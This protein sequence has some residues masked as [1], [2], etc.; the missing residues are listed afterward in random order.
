MAGHAPAPRK[1][2]DPYSNTYNPGWRD[3]PNLSYGGNRQ[4]NFVPNRQQGHQQQY[5]PRPPPP[6]PS[7]SSPSME[8]MMKQLLAN[9]QK[10]DSDLQSMRNQLGQVQSLQN[11]MNQMAITI[12]RLES[13]V[14]G[15]LPSQPEANPKNV[16]AM[17][18]RSGKE[19]QGPEPVIPKDKDEERIEKELEEEGRDNKNTKVPSNPIPTA[20][21][22]PPPF[23]SR[24]E[25]PKKQDK[26]KEV[27]EIFRKVE[28]NIP[29]LDAIKQVPRYAKFLRDLC[30]NRKRLKGDERVIVGENVSAILQRKLPPKC[31]DPGM[32]TI[33][34]RI[35]NI[36]IGKAMLDLGAS[37]NV[38]PKSIY[39]SLNLG[40]LKETGIIIQL[41]DRTN[42]YPD[43]LI[44]DVL[45][46]FEIEDRDELE[47]V[48]TKHFESE[49][50]SGVELS[51]ELKCVI[52]S[53]Q[54]LPTTKTRYDL[55]PIFIPEPHKRL[56]PSVVQA[57][58]LELKPLPKHLKYAYLGEGETLPVIISAGLSK[59]QEEK[60]LRVLR[61]HK[62]AIRWTIAN[63]KGISPAVCMH[64]IR[65]EENSKPVRQAQRRLNP[66]M[67]EVVKKEILKLLDV[68]IIFAISDSPWVSPVQV[69]PKKAGV[70][71][72]SNQEGELVPIRKPTGWR[73]CIDYRKLNAVTKKDHFPLPFIDQM[74]ER[75]ACR[76]YYCF[77]DGF[78]GY[79]QIAIAPEDQEKTTFTCPFGTFAY[80]RMPFGLCNA[81]AT[82]QRCMVSIFSEY[83]EKIIEVFMD[84]FSVYGI[85]VDKAKID[86]IYTLPYP[87]SVREV[88]SFLGHAGFYRRF[89]KD[90][91]K[92][93]APLFQLLQK[94]VSFEF[95]ETCKGAFNKLKEL[96]TTSPIIQ[97]PDWNLPFEIMCDAS[98]Y[99][100]GAVLGQRVG[101]AAHAIY[102]ASRALNGAQL[103][104]STTE[105]ELLAVVFALEKFRSYLL[106]AKVIIF[107]DHAALRYLLTKKE[108]KPRLIRWILL[109][110]EFNLEIRD[111]KG[112]ENLV[113]DH[114]SRV[115]VVEEDLP[116]R[117][118]FPEEH[119]FSINSSL[120]WYA[121]IVN[122]IVTDKFP[123]GWP[124][125]KRD[126]LRS[127]AKFYIWDDPYL[128]KR[129][130]DQIIRRCVCESCDKCQRVGNISRRDQMT[131]T[132]MIFVEIFDVWGIDFMGPFPSSF[133]FL[134]ILLA[135]DYVSKW[136]EAKATRTNDSKVVAEFVKSNIF[137]RFGMPRAIVSDRGTHFCNKTI[138]AIFRRYGVLH[139]VSTSYHPQT[140]GQAE[141]SNRE[142][143]SILEKMVR[144][145]RKDWSVRLED[146]LWAYR[147]AYK[148]PIGMSPYRLVFG[149]PC[150][151]PIEFEHRAFWAVK[152]CNMDIEE[153]GI[154][155]K[156]QLQELEEIRNE[157]YENAVI[158]KEKN[159]IFH[160]QQISRK[161]FFL[162]GFSGYFQIAIAPEDQEKTTFTC[163]FGTFAYR[164]MPFGLCNAPATFQRCM[165][166]IFSEYVEKIIE[167]FMDDFSVYGD[168]FDTCLDNLK[169]I[170]IR[171][172]ETNLV[173]NWEKC[174][175]MVEH[176]IVLGHIVSSKGIE[177][178]K[179]KIDIISALPYP[180][181][182]REVRSFLGHAGFYRR[183]IKDFSKIG[184]PLFQLLQKD[185]AFEFDDMCERAF[186]KLK[187]LLTSPPIIQP[188]DWNLPFEIMCDASDYAVGAV[189]GQRVGKAAHVIY[190]ADGFSGY[191]QIAIA[192]EDQ[193]KTTFTC[194]F[195]TFAYRRMPF[196]LCNAPATFQRCMVS[197]FSEY[198]EK[199]IEVFMDDFSVYGDSFDTCLDNLKLI[200]IRCIETNLV[201]NW[202]KCHFMV[203]HGIVLG[204]IVS[205]K[206]IEV[207]KAKIDI[208]SA[209]PYPASVRE[210]RSFLG[211]AGFYRRFIKDFSKI[212]APLFQLLQKDVAFEFDDMCERAFNKLKE[213]LTSPPIIQPPDWNLPF[214][215]M[216]DA[217]D[218]AVGAVLGQRVGKAAHVIYY[219]SRA[220]NGAQLNYFTTEKELLAVI[221]ALEKFRSYLLGAK[222]IVFSDHAA[223]RYLM[224]KKDAKPR[225]IRWIL[226]LQEFD[227]EIR[228]KKGSENL[229]A[230]HLSRILVEEDSEPLKDAFPEEHL[231][232]LNSQLPWYADLVNYLVT[233]DF[234]AGWQK[235]KRDKLKSDA[236]YFI[237]DDP[238]LW[239]RCADQ[240]MRRCVS[241]MEFQSILAFCHTFAC[242]GHFGPKR[243]AHKVLESG[244]YWPSLFKDAYV[245][246]KS[247]DRCQ[248]AKATRTNDSRVVADF[249]RSN[250]FV[251]FGMP[252]AIVSDRGTHFCNKTI[253]ALFRK[254]GVLHRVSTSYHPQ[255]NGQAEVSNREIKSI[256]EKMVRPDRK[257]W[258]Q[259]LEDAL[260]AYRTAYKTPIGMSPYRLVFGKPCHLPVEFEHKAFW[261]IKQCNMNLEEAG[262]QRKLDLQELE[263]IRNEAYENALIYKEKSRAFHDQQISR[264]TF[265]VGQKVL[266]Y[267]SRLKL[268][269]GKLRSRWIGPFIVTHVFPY[270]AVEIQSAKT[271]N[272]FVVNGHRLKYYYEEF[273]GREVETIRLDAPP[274]P[275]Q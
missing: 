234:P 5:H 46:V 275:N 240:V 119:L 190:Y 34:C 98:D 105:K 42:A 50:T 86:V 39:A 195:G 32:F 80:R 176:G 153:G 81:P 150:H 78:S 263:E 223:L 235:S 143:K 91:S 67:M 239:K 14:Q 33:P 88:R 237:W 230:D 45:E 155:R 10:T 137:V 56:L 117:E 58:V 63:I 214:E 29:L 185:V 52:G 38:M 218:Y 261:A 188:P 172:I 198:V 60:L 107:S 253:A 210:V 233:G 200:L 211:H 55:A 138:A 106:G 116:L 69:V 224:T 103:N 179:A 40:P 146:A 209:L 160:D 258:S 203:E 99:A 152:Q 212:G 111:K 114:L 73:Q 193:E 154:Q 16:S 2:Y 109:L 140:N 213:L 76:A 9:Q 130:A 104:Y 110:Q 175:F 220:L 216:C 246:C 259:R 49:T 269:P 57:P 169:L 144:P 15:K 136:V 248:R 225:L 120:P 148:T 208:I 178:D 101:K 244:F 166:S 265:E 47:V 51:E 189:L 44:E 180:A 219:A 133:G 229:V 3:H 132:P 157:A 94:D 182:V 89:I 173:L 270:G 121:D 249:I 43:G 165:V 85:E 163:P 215:I 131:Q 181:S 82:F 170:L 228:D 236:K 30:A 191:F 142:I 167:V 1:P 231:F 174:H 41:A 84:D 161:I 201:L 149:K 273:S 125:A 194:P 48:L 128:W 53:L 274:C 267:Q 7:N 139:K 62:Q 92:I 20:K 123:T 96:L 19:V 12:N 171:C 77:L 17:T 257:D 126:K 168:S 184:A 64:R 100:V 192:P 83:V 226:L 61:E 115:Q 264:K 118:A 251:R 129:G 241:E 87:A 4:S 221:F 262:V 255:T 23:P 74:V 187:E 183:F 207:D 164:R 260:W 147:T 196:G 79:F 65:L 238:Y 75:L 113:A 177:V 95:D 26:E 204:H 159:R 122:F 54:T 6:P 197:I 93:G 242:G 97:P 112:A 232:S 252:R 11:Q 135:V 35:G 217:S 28:I 199:I 145:D 206:G 21:T 205:S 102:Y 72:E 13:Q 141:A 268:F 247:C 27:L 71:V 31:G 271:D 250:I 162:D 127:D 186:N 66:L 90:F 272:K 256:L 227:L 158:Y 266:L 151:L 202:E 59:V 68:G 70:T 243:T 124:K 108:A 134:Y 222:V 37:I 36:L 254:Y 22:N 245:F 25:K 8:E 18:L 156:L 24:L